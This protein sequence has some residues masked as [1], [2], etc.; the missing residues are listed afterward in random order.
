MTD[1]IKRGVAYYIAGLDQ[2]TMAAG[3]FRSDPF[4]RLKLFPT[5]ALARTKRG[6]LGLG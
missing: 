4:Y 3:A 5:A 1:R 2:T 6:Y